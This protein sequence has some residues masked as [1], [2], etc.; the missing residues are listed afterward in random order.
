[1]KRDYP[2]DPSYDQYDQYSR[3]NRPNSSIQGSS[4]QYNNNQRSSSRPNSSIQGSSRQYNNNN[5]D[6]N[7]ALTNANN[8]LYLQPD[9]IENIGNKY[10]FNI[11][12]QLIVAV[13]KLMRSVYY[14]NIG[15]EICETF[16]PAKF[17]SQ[18]QAHD[19]PTGHSGF[20]LI[21]ALRHIE[22]T[23][24]QAEAKLKTE[25]KSLEFQQSPEYKFVTSYASLFHPMFKYAYKDTQ[26]EYADDILRFSIAMNGY[27]IMVV[28]N[29]FGFRKDTYHVSITLDKT[30]DIVSV[31]TTGPKGEGQYCYMLF[32]T[33]EIQPTIEN[34]FNIYQKKSGRDCIREAGYTYGNPDSP[35]T[36][37]VGAIYGGLQFLSH[38]RY[39]KILDRTVNEKYTS[40]KVYAI[41]QSI[42]TYEAQI[43]VR[44]KDSEEIQ[45]ALKILI[46]IYGQP[47]QFGGGGK[48]MSHITGIVV[49]LGVSVACAFL[50][51]F[52]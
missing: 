34:N 19:N 45:E 50:S 28:G 20:D 3:R 21:R 1:M 33:L 25:E 13:P 26:D 10:E 41:W 9:D 22:R 17:T 46:P 23:L 5:N 4:R 42:I 16:N 31:H 48:R 27:G 36:G 35:K 15:D 18:Y 51:S 30:T 37:L 11:A 14:P 8:R 6:Q 44:N 32:N 49:G 43:S 47:E 12:L 7:P 29:K 40:D 38:I 24:F 2:N 39:Y 52:R